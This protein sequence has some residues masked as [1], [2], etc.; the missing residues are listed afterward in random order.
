MLEAID[1]RLEGAFG[2]ERLRRLHRSCVAVVGAGLLGGQLLHHL[3]MLQ[4]RTLIV[5]PGTVDA[6]N[7]GNQMFPAGSV[8]EPKALVR[9]AQM[10]A[11]NPSCPTRALPQRVEELGLGTFA[12]CDLILTGLDGRAS[13]L[14][15]NGMAQ[16]LGLDWIDA[17]VDGTGR[18]LLGTVTWLRPH[19]ERRAC[20]GC[21]YDAGQLAAIAR[22][23]RP[24]PCASWRA[25]A[26]PDAPPTFAASPFGALVAGWQMTWAIQALLGEDAER[27][28]HQLQ[29]AAA[30][31]P[32]V[33][34]VELS[35]RP[36]CAFPHQRLAPLRRVSCERVGELVDCARVDLGAVPEALV[37]PGRSLAFGLACPSCGSRSDLVRRCEAVSDEEARCDC[38]AGAER[39]PLEVGDALDGSRLRDL[40]GLRWAELGIPPEDLVTARA[41][42]RLTHYLLPAAGSDVPP[43]AGSKTV[44]VAGYDVST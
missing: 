26:P 20:L 4:I 10:R 37:F 43:A 27:A 22:E 40:A 42:G 38:S 32:R 19:D 8:G 25:A 16:R 34:T 13:R 12:G 11:L 28:G 17:A 18:R 33:R 14:A 2:R 9:A 24:N 31:A 41:A 30:G 44:P 39:V 1:G 36:A 23:V 6:E 35:R 29:I 15:V 5:E 3:A 7:I 21:R